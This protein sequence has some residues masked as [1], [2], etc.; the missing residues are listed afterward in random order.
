MTHRVLARSVAI[1]AAI[2][3]LVQS[4][5]IAQI[6]PVAVFQQVVD[7]RNQGDLDGVMGLIGDDAVRQDGACQ[8]NCIGKAALRRSF[9]QNIDEHFQATVLAAQS[10]G[11]TVSARAELRS[12]AFR[13]RGAERI[14]SDF[15]VEVRNG[16]ITLWSS[17]LDTNDPQ[18][19]AYRATV[20][21]QAT[22]GSPAA[23]PSQLPNTG[24][25]V[26]PRWLAMVGGVLALSGF[27]FRL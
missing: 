13:A 5:V 6:D 14:I 1:A 22:T 9:Q 7:A 25:S 21:A 26:D 3:S 24:V 8:P 15:N 27:G 11:S 2:G 12:D 17:T 23:P 20:Q 16:K 4:V 10:N 18:T 19:A